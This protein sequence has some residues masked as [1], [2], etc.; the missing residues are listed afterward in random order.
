[1]AEANIG[2]QTI[3]TDPFKEVT[4]EL[5]TQ[6]QVPVISKTARVV[7]EVI[8][9]KQVTERTETVGDSV[10]RT[11]VGIEEIGNNEPENRE[12]F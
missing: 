1:M 5:K 3:N 2:E 11:D 8:I 10:K 4:F 7:E 9:R 12:K 6:K